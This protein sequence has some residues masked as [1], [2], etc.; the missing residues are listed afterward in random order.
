MIGAFAVL[1]SAGMGGEASKQM[2]GNIGSALLDD[3]SR[4]GGSDPCLVSYFLFKTKFGN[5]AAEVNQ[6]TGEMVFTLVRAARGGFDSEAGAEEAYDE[7]AY[8]E[9]VE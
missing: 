7:S 5:I 8:E 1:T 3:R 2:A 6:V 4:S 9:A